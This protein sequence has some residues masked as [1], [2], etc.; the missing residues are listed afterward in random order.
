M[1]K[2]YLSSSNPDRVQSSP[3][4]Q[5]DE[6]WP[7]FEMVLQRLHAEGLYLHPHQLAEFMLVHG[8]PVN[9]YYVPAH[10]HAKAIFINENYQ[11]DMAQLVKE[12]DQPFWSF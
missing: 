10:L 5:P 8:L 4:S 6:H 7:T 11:G 9:L 1:A 12:Q 2:F 3:P